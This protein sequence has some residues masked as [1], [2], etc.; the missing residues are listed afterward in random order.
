MA[1]T[2]RDEPARVLVVFCDLNSLDFHSESEQLK[3][4]NFPV[5]LPLFSDAATAAAVSNGIGAGGPGGFIPFL[6]DPAVDAPYNTH[7]T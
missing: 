2:C 6:R 3:Q 7:F 5:G 1:L 4:G